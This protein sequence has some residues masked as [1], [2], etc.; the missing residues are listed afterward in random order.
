MGLHFLFKPTLL[1]VSLTVG[2]HLR[3][4]TLRRLGLMGRSACFEN[5]EIRPGP[6]SRLLPASYAYST[7]VSANAPRERLTTA[8]IIPYHPNALVPLERVAQ[9]CLAT[10]D[11]HRFG[12]WRVGDS[13]LQVF[14]QGKIKSRYFQF[15]C[16]AQSRSRRRRRIRFCQDRRADRYQLEKQ[17]LATTP[18]RSLGK[19]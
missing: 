1:P 2:I 6:K 13:F 17:T 18:S 3:V 16:P 11:L 5:H 12:L 14:V 15:D 19:A 10:L 7:E 9:I 8:R 4:E